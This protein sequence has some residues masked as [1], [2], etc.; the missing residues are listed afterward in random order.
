MAVDQEK[1][2]KTSL[3]TAA[4]A[5][6]GSLPKA[7]L[8]TRTCASS[9]INLSRRWSGWLACAHWKDYQR[10]QEGKPKGE[11]PEEEGARLFAEGV[12]AAKV[13]ASVLTATWRIST[14]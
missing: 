11:S 13:Y 4:I 2:C 12:P 3:P 9:L 8:P 5:S 10:R 1:S 7:C 6:K 14:P